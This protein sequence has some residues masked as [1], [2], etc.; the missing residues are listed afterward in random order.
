M[1][2]I[3]HGDSLIR[4]LLFKTRLI[5]SLP[6]VPYSLP[7]GGV[8]SLKTGNSDPVGLIK[9]Q[10]WVKTDPRSEKRKKKKRMVLVKE[11]NS[12][13][14]FANHLDRVQTDKDPH[15]AGRG[16]KVEFYSDRRVLSGP[17]VS[18]FPSVNDK[19]D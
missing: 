18:N 11:G 2:F 3:V 15:V 17:P 16:L 4:F 19:Y 12:S 7:G 8:P 5:H 10:S 1:N 6:P 13:C 9:G 14:P